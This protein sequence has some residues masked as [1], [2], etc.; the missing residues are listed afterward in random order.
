MSCHLSFYDQTVICIWTESISHTVFFSLKSVHLLIQVRS[1]Y[2]SHVDLSQFWQNSESKLP[3]AFGASHLFQCGNYTF[4]STQNKLSIIWNHIKTKRDIVKDTH[5][6]AV[7]SAPRLSGCLCLM[8]S[9]AGAEREAAEVLMW[10][11]RAS[12]QLAGVQLPL[13]DFLIERRQNIDAFSFFTQNILT[14][15]TRLIS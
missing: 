12:K 2:C 1:S 11:T 15:N 10:S 9:L 4:S 13:I 7:R 3:P 8:L 5:A 6:R 14:T